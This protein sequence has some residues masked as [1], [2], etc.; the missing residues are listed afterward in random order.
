MKELSRAEGSAGGALPLP[1][2]Y[3]SSCVL[4]WGLNT[5]KDHHHYQIQP[6]SV[7]DPWAEGDLWRLGWKT[8]SSPF[9]PEFSS[10]P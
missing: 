2:L 4:A 5:L 3:R 1:C 10:L 7:P 8:F 9:Q 6:L